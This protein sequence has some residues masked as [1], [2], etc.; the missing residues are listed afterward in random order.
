MREFLDEEDRVFSS[1]AELVGLT[2][3]LDL[4]LAARQNMTSAT[5]PAVCANT[6]ASV[7]A[8]RSLLPHSKRDLVRGDGSVDELL[9]KANIIIHT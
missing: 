4:A 6:D 8:W 3:S 2:R 9:F 5:A 7:T 1:F